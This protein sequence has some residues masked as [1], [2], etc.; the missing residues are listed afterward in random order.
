MSGAWKSAVAL[1]ALVA[2]LGLAGC[3]AG[4]A[5]PAGG[6]DATQSTNPGAMTPDELHAF[7]AE[8]PDAHVLDV[9]QPEE[10]ND[11][12]GHIEGSTQIPLPEL[13]ARI[14]EIEAWKG[15]P[16]I[17]VCTVGARSGQAASILADNGFAHAYNLTGGL[18]AWRSKRY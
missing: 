6:G 9:R 5:K 2:A 17:A 18:V 1:A 7:L 4:G 13:P 3:G 14:G 12:Y 15:D 10:W 8:H 16:V 11:R